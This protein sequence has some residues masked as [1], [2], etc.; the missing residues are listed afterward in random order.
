MVAVRTFI[1]MSLAVIF[2][3]HV[4]LAQES[5]G[6]KERAAADAVA[7]F[8]VRSRA[9]NGLPKLRRIKDG[10]LEAEARRRAKQ[11]DKSLGAS[12]GI[13]PPEKVGTLSAMWYSTLD[14]A[15]PPPE[16]LDWAKGPGQQYEQPHRFAV[17]VCLVIASE[18]SEQRYWIVV[19]TY[20]SAIKSM[21]NIPTWD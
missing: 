20:M 5:L 12:D 1:A 21:L 7:Q 11:G 10:H 6:V 16:L 9:Q 19:G 8:I 17:G 14:P 15:Q 3:A 4:L 18:H 13:G 2:S